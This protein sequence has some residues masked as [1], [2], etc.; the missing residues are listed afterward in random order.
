[1]TTIDVN[2]G[3][4]VGGRS[5]E[6]TVY[7]TNLEATQAIARAE[8]TQ[9]GGIIILDFIDMMEEEHKQDVL[10]KCNAVGTGLA[11]KPKSHK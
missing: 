2:T 3:S 8:I 5:L 10:S 1:M 6:D 7:K 9:F 11:P 4:F